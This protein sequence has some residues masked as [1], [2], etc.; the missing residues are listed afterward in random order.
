[1]I[2]RGFREQRIGYA[3][4]I[5]FIFFLFVLL[6]SLAQKFVLKSEKEIE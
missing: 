2:Q 6:V 1:V 3:S 4:A 5:T